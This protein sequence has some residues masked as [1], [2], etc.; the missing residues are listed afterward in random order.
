MFYLM[1]AKVA[2]FKKLKDKSFTQKLNRKKSKT[3]SSSIS[4]LKTLPAV[5]AVVGD[6]ISTI[7]PA[8]F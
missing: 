6:W 5:C 7:L 8:G 2:N 1:C 3:N 4:P